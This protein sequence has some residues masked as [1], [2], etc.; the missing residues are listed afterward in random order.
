MTMKD[1]EKC[2]K[3]IVVAID[4]T[5]TLE[6]QSIPLSLWELR[7]PTDVRFFPLP[8]G[9]IKSRERTAP[10]LSQLDYERKRERER[11]SRARAGTASQLMGSRMTR[12]LLS[13][14]LFA[15]LRR[16][17]S[18]SLSLYRLLVTEHTPT[19]VSLSRECTHIIHT[20]H[21]WIRVLYTNEVLNPEVT[22]RPVGLIKCM[23]L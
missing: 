21:L 9:I 23:P 1:R 4:A 19:R 8:E 16:S 12:L 17:L 18:L 3:G 15:P 2:K 11:K 10:A 22:R 7:N 5:R 14:P 6:R 13:C 20:S